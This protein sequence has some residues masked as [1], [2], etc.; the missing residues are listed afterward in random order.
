[1]KSTRYPF[2][3]APA[4]NRS[5]QPPASATSFLTETATRFDAEGDGA[6]TTGGTS[7]GATDATTTGGPAARGAAAP[8]LSCAITSTAATPTV[9]NTA[10]GTRTI[11]LASTCRPRGRI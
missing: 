11:L 4:M 2:F 1:M 5:S 8:G 6:A 7:E 10:V 9:V 3:L